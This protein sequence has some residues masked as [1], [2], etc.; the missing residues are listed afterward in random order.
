ME[1]DKTKG[2]LPVTNPYGKHAT[3][4][5]DAIAD[6]GNGYFDVVASVLAVLATNTERKQSEA[7]FEASRMLHGVS[8]F[9]AQHGVFLLDIAKQNKRKTK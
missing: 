6:C 4:V 2:D 8:S 7:L 9:L 5:R 3:E 1:M